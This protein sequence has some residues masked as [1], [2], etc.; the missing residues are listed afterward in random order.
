MT[1]YERGVFSSNARYTMTV[2]DGQQQW[3]FGLYD[4]M[5]HGPFP[6]GLVKQGDLA[7]VLAYSQSRLDDTEAV[8]HWFDAA[9]AEAPFQA[10]TRIGFGGDGVSVWEFAPLEWV[11]ES[12]GLVFSG[13]RIHVDF[14]DEFRK[15]HSEGDF[16][17]LVLT[18]KEIEQTFSLK[19]IHIES[20]AEMAGD[21]AAA[22]HTVLQINDLTLSDGSGDILA[23]DGFSATFDSQH[24]AKLTD[25]K[26]LY[27]LQRVRMGDIDLGSISLGSQLRNFNFEA[28][29]ALLAEYDAIADEHGVDEDEEFDLTAEDEQRLLEKLIPVVAGSPEIA[30]HPVTWRNE[31]GESVLSLSV[32]FQ[33]LAKPDFAGATDDL[34]EALKSAE[35]RLS[36]SRPMLLQAV[37]QGGTNDADRQFQMLAA[38][39]FDQ[40]V[41]R[42]EREGLVAREGDAANIRLH[43][44]DSSVQVNGV[45]MSVDEFFNRYGEYLP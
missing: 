37:A 13:G 11:D 20:D 40:Y 21:K 12:G 22:M 9:R 44:E 10:D 5:Q 28:F 34:P 15:S 8:K 26:M 27:E 39:M 25:V 1:E 36:V 30:L 38:L 24:H 35:F 42:L 3:Q 43:Y 33:P 7:P 6:W 31:K 23:A 2:N 14:E 17:S 32:K 45:P 19:G 41:A 29:S 18:D 16:A 4:R